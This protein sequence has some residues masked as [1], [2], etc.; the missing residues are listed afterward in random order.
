MNQN[1]KHFIY[2]VI[3]LGGGLY[4]GHSFGRFSAYRETGS[5][6]SS[7]HFNRA[8]ANLNMHITLLQLL[9][10]KDIKTASDKLESLVD[11]DL[12]ALA[13]YPVHKSPCKDDV[14]KAIEKAKEYREKYPV[15]NRSKE[16][17]DAVRRTF[18]LI[19]SQK[20]L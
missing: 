4:F 5:M 8:S 3:L 9:H 17:T 6:I 2:G 19:S 10:E 14:Q 1:V 13:R 16:V 18:D 20:C 7:S 11:G 15:S 12:I